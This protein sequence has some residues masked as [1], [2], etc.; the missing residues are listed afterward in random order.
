MSENNNLKQSGGGLKGQDI[1]FKI[2]SVENLFLSWKEFKKGKTRKLDVV[3]FE[4]DYRNDIYNLRAELLAKTYKHEKYQSFF[5]KDPKLRHIHKA[6]VRDRVLHHAVFRILYPIFDKCFIADSY[7]CRV[8]KGTHKAV[9]RLE[10][11]ASGDRNNLYALKCDIKKYFDSINQ[12]I[13]MSLLERKIGDKNVLWLINK[14]IKSFPKGLPLGNITSQLFA[15]IYLNELDKFIKHKLKLKYYIRY[16]DDFIIVEHD[17]AYLRKLIPI[18]NAFL[19]GTLKLALHPNKVVIRKYNQGI[20]FLGYVVFPNHR[21]LR[22][23]TEKRMF[24]KIKQRKEDL[25]LAKISKDSFD[26][27]M[28]SYFGVLSHCNSHK[29]KK[30]IKILVTLPE[31]S[32]V[33]RVVLDTLFKIE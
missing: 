17:E 33:A 12:D 24:R 10:C 7:S 22:H 4:K 31:C 5:V 2:T 29:L 23:K 14:I 11:F 6:S 9:N 21:T 1:F 16:C 27:T 15:N 18:I 25:N 32:N 20:D 19:M 26:Q 13:L 28:Q 30:E 3:L 8:G